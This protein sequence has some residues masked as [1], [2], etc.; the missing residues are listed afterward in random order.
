MTALKNFDCSRS[1]EKLL[2]QAYL[3]IYCLAYEN[4]VCIAS[5]VCFI[6]MAVRKYSV[7]IVV[8]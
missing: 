2:L 8:P 4:T 6:I 7:Y 5:D 3:L 1:L